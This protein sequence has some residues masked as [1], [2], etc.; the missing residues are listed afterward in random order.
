MKNSNLVFAPTFNKFRENPKWLVNMILVIIVAIASVWIGTLTTDISAELK[1]TGLSEDEVANMSTF[2][3]VFSYIGVVIGTILGVAVMFLVI[4]IVS[5]I[6]KSDAKATS[7]FAA[8]T[9][10][11]LITSIYGLIIEAIH[12]IMDLDPLKYSFTSL[13]IFNQSNQYLGVFDLNLLLGAYLFGVVLYATSHLKGKTALIWSIVYLVIVI[14][15]GLIQ[16]SAS[17]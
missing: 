15:I 11:T 5:K 13:R 8:T 10:M 4:L 6:M 14:G 1:E 12:A 2:T 16:A 9:F 17:L 7:L 3:T